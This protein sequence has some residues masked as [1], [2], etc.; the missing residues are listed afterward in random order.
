MRAAGKTCFASVPL[1]NEPGISGIRTISLI[2]GGGAG[3]DGGG[4]G[5]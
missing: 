2:R 1:E 4:G 3:G 5:G